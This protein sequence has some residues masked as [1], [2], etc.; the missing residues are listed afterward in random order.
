M[1]F[2]FEKNGIFH[3]QPFSWIFWKSKNEKN[4][5]KRFLNDRF[6]LIFVFNIFKYF[7]HFI[8]PKIFS[9]L[10][11]F[12]NF[13]KTRRRKKIFFELI[14]FSEKYSKC[15]FLELSIFDLFLN[16]FFESG[17]FYKNISKNQKNH[18]Q[19]NA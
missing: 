10:T 17:K 15:E 13:K 8:F 12:L 4:F 1:I 9:F 16:F 5:F 3:F 14:Q 2:E 6:F 19:K 11:F 18:F 7:S